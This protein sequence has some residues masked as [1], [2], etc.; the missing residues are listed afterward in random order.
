M[1]EEWRDIKGYEGIYQ[2][3]DKGRIRSLD[4]RIGGKRKGS[5]R[6][7]KG[8]IKHP[9][10]R[11]NGYLK[12]TFYKD[13]KSETRE[14]QRVVAETFIPNPENKAQVN[15]KDGNKENNCIENLEWVT[16]RE[17]SIHA[18]DVLDKGS[19][20][21]VAQFSRGGVLIAE[22]RSLRIASENIGIKQCGISNV[23]SGRRYTAGGYV[24]RYVKE[25]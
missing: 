3:S 15:H 12:I 21:R 18:R 23:L 4:R 20:K 22:Y 11:K 6:N 9:T 8:T 17:N 10:K 7:W 13:G 1:T 24:W 14:V 19:M 16:A 25:A 5:T 2:A